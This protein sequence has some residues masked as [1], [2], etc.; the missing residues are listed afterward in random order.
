LSEDGIEGHVVDVV[1]GEIFPG[2]VEFTE[3]VITD[4]AK[5]KSAPNRYLLPGLI[6]AHIHIE[7]S[8]LC[9]SRFAEAVIPHGTTAIVSDP[10]EIANVFGMEGIK[11]MI[12]D[13]E[14]APLRCFFTAPSCVPATPFETSGA[15]LT[16]ADVSEMLTWPEMVALGEMMNFPGAIAGDEEV[17]RKIDAAKKHGKPIDGHAPLLSGEDLKR[18]ISLGITTDHE[19]TDSG[20]AEEKHRAGMIVQVRQ[21]SA[22]RNLPALA[23]FAKAYPFMLVSD[24]KS[25]HDL[26][27]GHMNL[28]LRE[29]VSLGIEPLKALRATTL[30]PAKHYGLPGGWLEPGR[31]AD[32]A[33]VDDLQS[34]RAL[35]TWIA[36]IRV[37]TDGRPEFSVEPEAISKSLPRIEKQPRDFAQYAHGKWAKIRAIVAM[38]DEIVTGR[39]EAWLPVHENE[40]LPNVD[41]DLLRISVINRYKDAIVS[42]SFVTGFGLREGAMASTVAHDSHNCV[43]VGVDKEQIAEAAN[44]SLE[45]G[46]FSVAGR[47]RISRLELP[48]GGLMSDRPAGEIAGALDR[49]LEHIKELGCGLSSPFMTLSFMSL[50]VIPSLKLGDRGLFDVDRFEFVNPVVEVSDKMPEGVSDQ[51]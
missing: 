21:G 27:R 2:R 51:R 28:A 8:H 35:E 36:G 49:L 31:A 38:S 46:G 4:I 11:F 39:T 15:T 7:S 5:L 9:P 25:A 17:L 22:S 30:L 10:H 14:K 1:S 6:D 33:V 26:L 23:E 44:A 19:C 18:Y 12:R 50:L 32:I 20:E 47:G 34:F 29:A 40:V 41:R 37:A 24:D 48:I 43:T 42:N 16:H 45:K 3:G 13:S